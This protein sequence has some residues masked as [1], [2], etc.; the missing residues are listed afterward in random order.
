LI[1]AFQGRPFPQPFL[2]KFKRTKNCSF[3][4]QGLKIERMDKSVKTVSHY[5]AFRKSYTNNTTIVNKA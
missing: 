3:S 2:A 4:S 1:S 5:F